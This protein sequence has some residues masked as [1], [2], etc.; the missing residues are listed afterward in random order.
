MRGSDLQT[1]RMFCYS[2]PETFVPPDHP[3]RPIR[4]MVEKALSDLHSEFAAMYSHTGR[5][6]VPPEKLLKALLLQA[7]YSI[8]SIRLLMEQIQHDILFR[9]FVGLSL[10]DNVWDPSTFSQNQERLLASDVAK[11]FF[12]KVLSQARSAKLLSDEH[13][14]V[15]GTLIEAW[16]SLKS[17]RPKDEDPK[18]PTGRNDAVVVLPMKRMGLYTIRIISEYIVRMELL[19]FKS[20]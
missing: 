11:K 7:F 2:S 8:R 15:D 18:P 19:L 10:E 4:A 9:W 12:E 6:S 13:F 16:A 20:H 14:T 17:F 5:P 1:D 3:L